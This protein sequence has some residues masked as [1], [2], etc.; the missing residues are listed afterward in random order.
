MT[1]ITTQPAD[2]KRSDHKQLR[3]EQHRA[4]STASNTTTTEQSQ[5]IYTQ[6]VWTTNKQAAYS[7]LGEEKLLLCGI[8][9]EGNVVQD[10]ALGYSGA[11]VR[12]S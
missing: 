4:A 3:T 5:D 9:T 2:T 12:L 6:S 1:K 7:Y 8:S 11:P 10:A